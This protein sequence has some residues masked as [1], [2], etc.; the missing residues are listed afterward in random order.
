M[1]FVG[2]DLFA[3]SLQQLHAWQNT[4]KARGRQTFPRFAV[5]KRLGVPTNGTPSSE[6]ST[7]DFRRAT[8]EL[9][10]IATADVAAATGMPSLPLYLNPLTGIYPLADP[11]SD[12]AIGTLWT[13]SEDDRSVSVTPAIGGASGQKRQFSF[14]PDY[15]LQ[16]ATKLGSQIPIFPF[17]IFLA[18]RA[19]LW[20]PPG[21]T[22]FTDVV[23]LR[24][25]VISGLGLTQ[26]ELDAIF[27]TGP[28][29]TINLDPAPLTELDIFQI[30]LGIM[31]PAGTLPAPQ[32]SGSGTAPV[33]GQ[34][35]PGVAAPVGPDWGVTLPGEDPCGLRG[36][37]QPFARAR[38]ALEAGKHVILYGPPGTG[39]SQL[40]ECIANTLKVQYSVATATADWTSFDTV[41]GYFP[42]TVGG[43][44]RL[45]FFPGIFI[46]SIAEN[47]WLIVDEINRADIDKAFG[48]LFSILAGQ[49]V[50]LPFMDRISNPEKRVSIGPEG[51]ADI[52]VPISWRLIGTMNTFDKS[53]L[54]QLSYALMR[55]FAF[56]EV[57]APNNA[58]MEDI[59]GNATNDWTGGKEAFGE[60]LIKIFA[61]DDGL[62]GAGCEVGAAIPL[63]ICKAIGMVKESELSDQY[64]LDLLDM[65]LFPQFEGMDRNYGALLKI[66]RAALELNDADVTALERRLQSW[67]GH[68]K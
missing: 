30:A 66:F 58:L 47:K 50:I 1:G 38:T 59:L 33:A 41:G 9:F 67:T 68:R 62:R 7:L 15:I 49:K 40:A 13:R 12:W 27:D 63:D 2:K 8:D 14:K 39:K 32:T 28:P 6:L 60:K 17:S 31:P 54:F 10:G 51:T 19:T 26:A 42:Q 18:R 46:E 22:D 36:L 43:T 25:S 20:A 16:I 34:P 3:W 44:E 4:A 24:N 53:S 57:P 11:T 45:S 61:A 56:V 21:Q 52:G 37:G 5:L 65:Y 55:R 23:Q 48:S 29:P 35:Q 64:I